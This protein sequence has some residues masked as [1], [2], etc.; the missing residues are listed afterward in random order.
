MTGDHLNQPILLDRAST[1]AQAVHDAAAAS[2]GVFLESLATGDVDPRW[3]PWLADAWTKVARRAT[4]ATISTVA[5]EYPGAAL[6]IGDALAMVPMEVADQPRLVA[7][8]QVAGTDLPLSSDTCGH[9]GPVSV[10]LLDRLTTGK[11]AAQAAHALW[12]WA[13]PALTDEPETILD[14][15]RNGHPFQVHLADEARLRSAVTDRAAALVRDAGRSEVSP[16][17]LTA[18]AL[19]A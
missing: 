15:W 14:W 5:A 10:L 17:T 3:E 4:T 19:P 9:D 6:R 13:K 18:V 8:A 16:G 11:A 7:R 1:H 12:A 2:L